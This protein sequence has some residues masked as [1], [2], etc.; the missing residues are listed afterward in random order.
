MFQF[1]KP[2]YL[3]QPAQIFRRLVRHRGA[4]NIP[5]TV[6]LPWGLPM[7]V[8][9]QES[10]GFCIW[11]LGIYDL[12]LSEVAWRLLDPGEKAVDV[13]GNIGYMSCLLAA[14]AGTTGQVVT[15]EPHPVLNAALATQISRWTGAGAAPVTLRNEALSDRSG[16]AFLAEPEEFGTNC[17][18]STLENGGSGRGHSVP[19]LRLDSLTELSGPI[20]VM[21]VDVE[22]HEA[23]VFRGAERLLGSGSLR[24]IVFE[25][26]HGADS[27]A[28]QFLVRHGYT[29]F[30]IERTLWGP[31]LV[32]P[33]SAPRTTWAATNFLATREPDRATKRIGKR[34]WQVLG[35]H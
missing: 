32:K 24:D 19:T 27:E 18:T 5:V 26:H 1:L 10:I 2:E 17:G 34:G 6:R 11:Q 28:C 20:G 14:R 22:G 33:D 13:G 7:V 29:L 21:K 30:L 16:V 3:F 15:F 9:S 4:A 8:H 12:A 25:E 31:L 23:A 35:R